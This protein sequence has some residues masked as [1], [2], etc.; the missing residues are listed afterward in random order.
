VNI[1]RGRVLGL[2]FAF[3][4]LA[5]LVTGYHPG[6]ED[7]TVYVT[8]VKADLNPAL[9]PH[10]SDFFKLQLRSSIFNPAMSAFI[11]TT[12][13]PVSWAE[14]LW[15][16]LSIFLILAA[17]W[18]ILR[19]LFEEE[20]ARWAGIAMLAAMCTLPVAG[21]A[22]YIVDQ[23]LHPRA[24]A[25]ALILF[26]VS[27]IMAGRRWVA[28]PLLATAFV[29]HPLMGALGV[30]F[31]CILTLTLHEPLQVRLRELW[32]RPV[33]E[34]TT[35]AFIFLPF[36]WLIEPPSPI[37]L[38]AM[39]TRH[40]FRLYQWTWY[41][42][43]GA[44]GPLVIFWIVSRVA[45]RRGE[46]KLARFATAILFYGIFQQA[47]AMILLGPK[48][49][50]VFSA[51]EPM[52]YLHLVYVFM[53][54]ILGAYLGRYVL[55]AQVWRWAL[56]LLVANG[57]MFL[58]QRQLFASTEHLEL[59]G[60]A[61]QNPWLQSFAWIRENT[62]TSAYFVLDP[63]YMVA[64]QEDNHSFRALAERSQLVDAIKDT[65][66]ISKVPSL[67]PTW[68][69]QVS[70]QAGWTHFKLADFERLKSG[71]G[72]NWALVS[73]P[74]TAGLDCHWHNDLLAVCQIP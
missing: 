72:V 41:E 34:Y 68:D 46:I 74:A 39:A 43:L 52:R 66:V 21:T 17:S 58:V 3:S 67:G 16:F 35:S 48:E 45:Q 73:Y 15:Q 33:A 31:C 7:D 11:R 69:E 65:A 1:F 27:G 13:I 44:I 32:E 38:K 9:Y 70:A 56:F 23:Y 53:V 8:A 10:D 49:L 62:P 30:S 60:V 42:W 54:L 26:S 55:R 36:G 50:I 57:A 29:V 59:P 24:L 64:P 61:S 19:Q 14:L 18:T 47:V 37:W 28:F 71:F 12:H 63:N 6:A 5:F 51:L 2:L 22:L 40:W 4:I 20:I 25:A